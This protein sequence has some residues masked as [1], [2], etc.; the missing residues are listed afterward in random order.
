MKRFST[1]VHSDTSLKKAHGYAISIYTLMWDEKVLTSVVL[2]PQTRSHTVYSWR[3]IH[4]RTL[5]KIPEHVLCDTTGRGLLELVPESLWISRHALFPFDDSA[6]YPFTEISLSCEYI[7][8]KNIVQ[9][10]QRK[11]RLRILNSNSE[12]S[13]MFHRSICLYTNAMLSWLL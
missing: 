1:N 11:E 13:L 3:N 4:W 10:M 12:L 2:F 8:K 7:N 6:L 5:C 9:I